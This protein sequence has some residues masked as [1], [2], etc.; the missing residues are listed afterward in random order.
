MADNAYGP[1]ATQSTDTEILAALGQAEER[2]ACVNSVKERDAS[3]KS[4]TKK[5]FQKNGPQKS[6]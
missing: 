1:D 4:V 2:D 6:T 5:H 3:V